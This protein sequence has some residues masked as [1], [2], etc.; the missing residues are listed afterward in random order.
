MNIKLNAFIEAI[1]GE[2]LTPEFDAATVE[3][4]GGYVSDLL[5]DVMGSAAD[6]QVWITIM[7]HLNV[8]AVASLAG[9][10]A[11]C[12]AKGVRPDEPV[13]KKA[14]EENI[15]LICSDLTTFEL[16]GKLYQLL[17]KV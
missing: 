15:S 11:I 5:S 6:N 12:F 17:Y 10:S 13:I 7:K 8:V 3:V 4:A 14:K 16:S 1:N 9:I 2:Y